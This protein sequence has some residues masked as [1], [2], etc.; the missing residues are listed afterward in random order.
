MKTSLYLPAVSCLLTLISAATLRGNDLTAD[1]L[2]LS[3]SATIA[4]DII[5]GT[6][7]NGPSGNTIV[8][9]AFRLSV[10]NQGINTEITVPYTVEGHYEDQEVTT[11]EYGWVTIWTMQPSYSWGQIGTTYIDPIYDEFGNQIGGGTYEPL[12]G[13]IYMG[14][15]LTEQS[16]WEVIGTTTQWQNVWVDTHQSFYTDYVYDAPKIQFTATRSDANWAWQ[17]PTATAGEVKDIMVLWNGGLRLP[18]DDANRLMSLSS[19]SLTQSF[20]ESISAG[21]KV[22]VTRLGSHDLKVESTAVTGSGMTQQKS[23]KTHEM[24]PESL[25]LSRVEKEGASPSQVISAK[26]T[27]IAADSAHFGGIVTVE[28]DVKVK[29][30][31]RVEPAGNLTMGIYDDGPRPLDQ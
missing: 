4:G 18:S 5:F 31:M 14:E 15:V 16:V 2:S 26:Q 23:E 30:V 6:V 28:G 12:Y 10:A 29:G 25:V 1:N 24:K 19:D 21:Q 17:V 20:T 11:P 7:Y 3:A 27:Q 9:P 13:D 22:F 8:S